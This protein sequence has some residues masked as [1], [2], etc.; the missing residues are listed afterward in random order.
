MR[1]DAEWT[2]LD[3]PHS[4]ERQAWIRPPVEGRRMN[5]PAH[6]AAGKRR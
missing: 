1:V 5:D 4:Q 3:D 2:R 6:E